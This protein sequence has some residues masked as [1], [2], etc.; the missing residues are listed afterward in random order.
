MSVGIASTRPTIDGIWQAGE[1]NDSIEYA[2]SNVN[3]GLNITPSHL[4]LIHDDVSLYG[5]VDAHSD[6]RMNFSYQ[7][8]TLYGCSSS[9]HPTA[10][11]NTSASTP[12]TPIGRVGGIACE[13][14]SSQNYTIVQKLAHTAASLT[15][16]IHSKR[17]H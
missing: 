15:A 7:G 17:I 4:R 10:T 9:R 8:S 5:W 12:T 14:C 3:L 11:Y 13:E 1:W 16:T 2:L 6:N